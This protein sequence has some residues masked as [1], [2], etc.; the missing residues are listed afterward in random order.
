MYVCVRARVHACVRA[1]ML[2]QNTLAD[3]DQ[4]F[5]KTLRNLLDKYDP[6]TTKECLMDLTFL[7]SLLK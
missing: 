1:R 7:G 2:I 3:I 6:E 5:N 4:V